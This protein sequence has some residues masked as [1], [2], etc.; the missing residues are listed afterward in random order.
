MLMK[1]NFT[2]IA[3][4]FPESLDDDD[5][6]YSYAKYTGEG[7]QDDITQ[8]VTIC[9]DVTANFNPNSNLLIPI[10]DYAVSPASYTNDYSNSDVQRDLRKI[11]VEFSRFG[12]FLTIN[13]QR[14]NMAVIQGA[15]NLL[16]QTDVRVRYN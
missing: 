1:D 2:E 5:E 15:P 13:N 6:K 11:G 8:G 14:K 12:I 9:I 7:L 10:F 4:R 16:L 3:I